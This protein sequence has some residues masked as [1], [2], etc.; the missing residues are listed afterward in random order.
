MH[1]SNQKNEEHWLWKHCLIVTTI[2][3]PLTE[4]KTF[5]FKTAYF[6]T[7]ALLQDAH[8]NMPFQS[9]EIRPHKTNAAVLS[10]IAA[11]IEI[12]IEIKVT[13]TF[14]L[15]HTRLL[16][17]S[18]PGCPWLL[19]GANSFS[20]SCLI[21]QLIYPKESQQLS[22]SERFESHFSKI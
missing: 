15:Y 7:M 5:S 12:E 17:N 1:N 8:I 20:V 10:I 18:C 6:G 4:A 2:F 9:W 16:I 3:S 13:Q 22:K 19:K 21:R 14:P 11:I